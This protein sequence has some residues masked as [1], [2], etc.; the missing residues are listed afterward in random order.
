MQTRPNDFKFF[1]I[2]KIFND[3]IESN[4]SADV[5]EMLDEESFL[6]SDAL[7]SDES[8]AEKNEMESGDED[9]IKDMDEMEKILYYLRKYKKDS[10]T[11]KKRVK[12]DETQIIGLEG[13]D[14]LSFDEFLVKSMKIEEMD[15]K[16]VD[17]LLRV[18]DE[19]NEKDEEEQKEALKEIII[20]EQIQLYKAVEDEETAEKKKR[21]TPNIFD[22]PMGSGRYDTAN[23]YKT[24]QGNFGLSF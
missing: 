21:K 23:Q 17:K 19:E 2:N 11:K 4:E 14:Y 15:Q 6:G 16:L 12:T 5:S 24:I 20:S 7:F 9:P 10:K 13:N 22:N 1:D 8:E 18:V 3:K